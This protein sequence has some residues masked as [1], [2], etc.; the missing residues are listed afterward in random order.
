MAAKVPET[1]GMLEIGIILDQLVN[2]KLM[3]P[4]SAP[5]YKIQF[6]GNFE[7]ESFASHGIILVGEKIFKVCFIIL[8]TMLSL[9]EPLA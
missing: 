9:L 3:K 2:I 8:N 1:K 4:E 7:I 6:E 5:P